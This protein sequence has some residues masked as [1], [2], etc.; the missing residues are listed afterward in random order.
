MDQHDDVSDAD[1]G[2]DPVV[3]VSERAATSRTARARPTSL[4]AALRRA[5][6]ES[7]ERADVVLD[8]R[9]AE[10]TRLEMLREHLAPIF[11]EV[12]PSCD[13]F[14]PGIAP[15]ERPRLFVDAVAFI[16][17]ARDRRSYRFVQDTR[18]GRTVLSESERIEPTVRAVTDYIARRL[19][20]RE[21]ALATI[22]PGSSA[23]PQVRATTV[24]PPRSRPEGLRLLARAFLFLVEIVGSAVVFG[25]LAAGAIWAWQTYVK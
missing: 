7:A 15:G 17:M 11:D 3:P 13:M 18:A 4:T 23:G 6:I 1:D 25:A 12:P 21:R 24:T 22:A 10:M 9:G 19:V 2:S 14:D 16:E 20:E 5:R 8:L